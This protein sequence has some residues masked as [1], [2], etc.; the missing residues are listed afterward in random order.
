[1]NLPARPDVSGAEKEPLLTVAD[2]VHKLLDRLT[3]AEHKAARVLLDNYPLIGLES[4]G[5]VAASAKVS[6]PTVLRFVNKLGYDGYPAF[7][8]ALRTEL[9]SRLQS[10][11]S[12]KTK[13][14]LRGDAP[15]FLQNFAD[16]ICSNVQQGIGSLPRQQFESV[17]AMLADP[18]QS[19]YLLGGRIT[20]AIAQYFY[21]HLRVLRSGVNQITG[22]SISW[23]DYLFDLDSTKRLIVFDV[24]RYQPDVIQ[25]AQ[26]A[27]RRDC[28][29]VLFTDQWL[30]PI[31][32]VA[33]DVFIAHIDVPSNW[34]SMSAM[35][36]QVEALIAALNYR[37]WP[38][39]EPRMQEHEAVRMHYQ[40]I[41]KPPS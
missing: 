22:P 34:D 14:D 4:L 6:H 33:K 19:I 27:A 5:K 2:R 17:L 16:T 10:P 15:D 26:E 39:L 31:A 12:K 30:S 13:H 41:M 38:R 11:L 23:P 36:A 7:Q 21:M 18:S 9:K 1:V 24:R 8:S 3:P 32:S 20:D 40:Q 29:V 25:F 28:R 37:D 35:M